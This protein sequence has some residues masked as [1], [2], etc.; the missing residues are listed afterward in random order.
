MLLKQYSRSFQ[1]SRSQRH[2]DTIISTSTLTT[3]PKTSMC[4]VLSDVLRK[5]RADFVHN[6]DVIER[7]LLHVCTGE[8]LI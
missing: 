4:E 1:K 8:T 7:S 2:S 6:N 3:S 5:L